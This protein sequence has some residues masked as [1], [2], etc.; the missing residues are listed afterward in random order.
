MP[1]TRFT[2]KAHLVTGG[3]SGIGRTVRLRLGI[4]GGP[5]AVLDLNEVHAKET[6]DMTP[7]PVARLWISTKPEPGLTINSIPKTLINLHS[8]QGPDRP[9]SR[10]CSVQRSASPLNGLQS[11][12]GQGPLSCLFTI[13]ISDDTANFA[14]L[15]DPPPQSARRGCLRCTSL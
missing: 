4:E 12:R 8:R 11:S 14:T 1:A 5:M 2:D 7:P 6:A 10:S 13:T 9:R 3:R 15:I